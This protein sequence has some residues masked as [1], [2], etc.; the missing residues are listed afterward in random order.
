[1]AEPYNLTGFQNINGYYDVTK[2]ANDISG[3]VMSIYFLV[4]LFMILFIASIRYGYKQAF[5]FASFTIAF[6]SILF[7]IMGLIP[8]HFMFGSFLIAGAALVILRWGSDY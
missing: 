4:G 1:M 3:G 2:A 5:G 8:D 6:I 7:R